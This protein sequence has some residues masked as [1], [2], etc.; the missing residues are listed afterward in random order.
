MMRVGRF[1]QIALLILLAAGAQPA[2]SSFYQWSTTAS[3]NGT[4]DPSINWQEGMS[5]SS[6]NDSARAMMAVLAVW[7]GEVSGINSAGGTSS[8]LTIA[9]QVGYPSLSAMNGQMITFIA[10]IGNAAAATLNVDG[11]GARA[12]EIASLTPIPANTLSI[13]GVYTVTYYNAIS[14][15]RLHSVPNNP[16]NV[17][18]GGIIHSTVSTAPNG[19]FVEADGRCI[20]TTT[21]AVYW[22]ALGSPASGACAGGQ[23]AVL[24]ARGRVLPGLDNLGGTAALRLTAG[25]NGCGTAMTSLG[26]SCSNGLQSQNLSISNINSFTPTVSSAT[27]NITGNI[28]IPVQGNTGAPVPGTV[29]FGSN[30]T[31]SSSLN[32][33]GTTLGGTA[34]VTMNAVGSGTAHPTTDPNAAVYIYIRV[35]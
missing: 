29:R 30:D 15:F 17:P 27:L 4:A 28:T 34:S 24:D 16:Y 20:S 13:G 31:V 21:Y 26:A 8:A 12:I 1:L 25:G 7:R 19:N 3:N 11:L 2:M 18:L 5:P 35:L 10:T 9:S 22:V 6:V 33:S 23:F 32:V 14:A